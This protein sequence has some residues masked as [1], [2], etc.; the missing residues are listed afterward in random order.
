[1]FICVLCPLRTANLTTFNVQLCFYSLEETLK[2]TENERD[3]ARAQCHTAQKRCEDLSGDNS[4]LQK[5]VSASQR[6]LN[7]VQSD[8]LSASLSELDDLRSQLTAREGD[9]RRFRTAADDAAAELADKLS[10]SKQFMT[11]KKLIATK[12]AQ[13]KELR[14]KLRAL[15]PPETYDQEI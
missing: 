10:S 15:E 5:Q 1:M 7:N 6:D 14:T 3:A 2:A 4:V 12:N 11:L 8:N 13:L 9:A